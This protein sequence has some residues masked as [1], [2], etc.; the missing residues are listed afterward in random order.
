[1]VLAFA[2]IV[3]LGAQPVQLPVGPLKFGEF[4]ANFRADGS[5]HLEGW[6]W[7]DMNGTWK[8]QSDEITFAFSEKPP[9]GCE[10]PACACM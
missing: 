6:G 9:K 8:L 10:G 2:G 3:P 7:P 1:M 5:F 4:T